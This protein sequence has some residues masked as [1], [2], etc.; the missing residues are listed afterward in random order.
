MYKIKNVTRKTILLLTCGVLGGLFSE[1]I[2]NLTPFQVAQASKTKNISKKRQPINVQ[3]LGINDLHGG[4]QT[5]GKFIMD[6]KTFENA[7][8]S[9]RLGGYLDQAQTL[10]HKKHKNGITVRVQSGDMIGA[11]PANSA[12]LDDGPTLAALKAMKIQVGVIGNHEFDHGLVQ[13]RNL[14]RG[15][16]PNT[17]DLKNPQQVKAI[18]KYPFVDT[19]MQI[20]IANVTD[21]KT[22]KIPA[23]WKPYTIKKITDPK[24]KAT[25][26]IGYIG[27][28]NTN[29]PGISKNYKLVNEAKTISKY[30]K[31]LRSKGVKAIIVLGHT[32]AVTQNGN[33]TGDAVNDLKQLN[34][35]DPH[36]SVD[37]FFA[38][39]S[40][41][42]ANG[43]INGVPVVQ[44]GFQGRGYDNI[45][46]KINPKTGDFI[47]KSIKATVSPVKALTDDPKASF[48]KD[49]SFKKINKIIADANKRVSPIINTEVGY[50]ANNQ[51]ISNTLSPNKESAAA[52]AV[53]DAQRTIANEKGHPADIAITSNDSIRSDMNV[54]SN[55]KVT[56][57]SL[58]DM[59]PYGNSQPIV[60]MTGKDLINLLNEQYTKTQLYYLQISGLTYHY[61]PTSGNQIYSVSDVSTSDGNPL[62]LTKKYRVLT[63]D[64]LSTGGDGYS[65]F[66][67]GSIVDN[68][69]Q[70]IDLLTNYLQSHS[71]IPVPQLNRKIPSN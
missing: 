40:H 17:S 13:Y 27:I 70:D 26:K 25:V 58:Y 22:H 3:F 1:T 39:H 33:T 57:G 44:A 18:K 42:Y 24:T 31:K 10:F 7:G 69:G 5:T 61:A 36:N 56:L 20:V 23:N 53:V 51:S 19:K 66:T 63:N 32:G 2:S 21:R 12:L 50:T 30:D 38:G 15:K 37:L 8:S 4:L 52:Y 11:S 41:Q 14:L 29:L 62:S 49:N 71:P 68:A 59:Q 65:A 47:K 60:E 67:R 64:Y 34:K 28:L 54:N 16:H 35:I 9:S 43:K 6:Q 55:G 48:K 46:A 45:T